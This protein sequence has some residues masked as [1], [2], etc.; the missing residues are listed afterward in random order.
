L[1]DLANLR[2]TQGQLRKAADLCQEALQEA[3]ERGARQFAPV[4]YALVKLGEI[5][6]ARNDLMAAREHAGE[7][8]AL[9]QGWQ[10]PY[11]MVGGY[12]TLATVLLA[13][14][15]GEGAREA[16]QNAEELHSQHP[17]YHKL[18][19]MV[20]GCRIRLCLAQ[21]G[22]DEAARQAQEIRLGETGAPLFREQEQMVLARVLIAQRRWNEA[23]QLLAQLAAD[24][25]AGRRFG[26]LLEILTLEAVARY[27]Q[28]DTDGALVALE[29]ALTM[30]EPEGYVRVFVEQGEAMARLL[31]KADTR[32]IAPESV[33]RLLAVLGMEQNET[34]A[35][36]LLSDTPAL[37][38]PL[39]P[40]EL[41]VLQLLGEGCSNREIAEALVITING[42]KKH[43]SNIYGKLGV[44]SRT[45][46]VVRAQE[47]GLL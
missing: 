28:G 8:V 35:A 1:C 22:P 47:L 37:V 4:G 17:H 9:M 32:G 46:A 23:Q 38:E 44:H 43:T 11:E 19:S 21:D 20:H 41:E 2:I 25:E 39:T 24:T 29:K 45:Q 14:S 5:F 3:E 27:L 31:Q 16:L 15:D 18:D 6:Y 7:G 36:P 12:T 13:Q 42:V 30:A 26:R 33:T 40:R 10:Q 34:A